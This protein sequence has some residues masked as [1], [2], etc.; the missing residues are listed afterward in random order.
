MGIRFDVTETVNGHNLH[1]DRR[2]FENYPQHKA[3]DTAENIDRN[4]EHC[5]EVS[6]DH[7]GIPFFEAERRIN[8]LTS[9]KRWR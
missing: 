7:S 1:F 6:N 9:D 3:F 5:L 8:C 4:F 2:E